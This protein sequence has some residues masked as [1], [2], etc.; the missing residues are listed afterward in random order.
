MV[1]RRPNRLCGLMLI[2]AVLGSPARAAGLRNLEDGWL[3]TGRWQREII[4]QQPPGGAQ[5]G[6]TG[7]LATGSC[8]LFGMAELPVRG[9]AG[10][11]R[12]PLGSRMMQ[13][14]SRW[15]LTGTDLFREQVWQGR[16]GGGGAGLW[17]VD[18]SLTLAGQALQPSGV[19][20]ADVGGVVW[21]R[22][23]T[24]CLVRV[25]ASLSGPT[26][27]SSE[28][29]RRR[30]ACLW[31][32]RPTWGLG[33]DVDRSWAGRP[34]L[35]LDVLLQAGPGTGVGLRS[36]PGSGTHGPTLVYGWGALLLRTCHLVHP[37]LGITH[38]VSLIWGIPGP[39]GP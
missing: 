5:A 37:D 15:E 38:R 10:G 39:S 29:R 6:W 4:G 12:V 25:W 34:G 9:L 18:R 30:L 22:G 20:G 2:A 24:K 32:V 14:S 21:E 7:W 27:R 13:L 26:N 33:L 8:R 11:L 16:L 3:L 28:P 23:S 17:F 19:W 36:D 35:T 31:L 1:N